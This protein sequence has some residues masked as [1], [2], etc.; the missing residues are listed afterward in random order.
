MPQSKKIPIPTNRGISMLTNENNNKAIEKS[1]SQLLRQLKEAKLQEINCTCIRLSQFESLNEGI[2]ELENLQFAS[3][4][5]FGSV[6]ELIEIEQFF[7]RS[8]ILRR[9]YFPEYKSLIDPFLLTHVE[10]EVLLDTLEMKSLNLACRGHRLGASETKWLIFELRNL[11][12]WYFS[13]GKI[14]YNDYKT[15]ALQAIN[16][17]RPILEQHRGYKEIIGNLF[18]LILTLGTAFLI[19]K[20]CSGHFFFFKQTES[21]KQ[22]DALS[23]TI[24]AYSLKKNLQN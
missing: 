8:N 18:L 5:D 4:E 11:N 13:E 6:K 7:L 20:A 9:F 14:D 15:R 23:Q 21:T 1:L 19:N 16:E 17:S 2:R 10:I 24:N 3:L 22:I 12:H